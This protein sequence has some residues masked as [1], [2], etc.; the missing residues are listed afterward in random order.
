MHVHVSIDLHAFGTLRVQPAGSR[1][2][3]TALEAKKTLL[4]SI[5]LLHLAT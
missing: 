3:V 5:V 1:H 2:S 4:V